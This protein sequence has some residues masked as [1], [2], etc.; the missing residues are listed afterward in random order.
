M[1]SSPESPDD[2]SVVVKEALARN[3]R[4]LREFIEALHICPYARTCREDGRLH[5]QVVLDRVPDAPHVAG[6]IRDLDERT[7]IEVGLLLFPRLRI[8]PRPFERFIG[9][10]CV[11]VIQPDLSRC[12]GLT[13]ARRVAQMAHDAGIDL[14]PHSWLTHLLTGYSL[15]LIAT[16]PRARF[17]EFNV[18]Q[19]AL[20][21]G[22]T[23]QPFRLE[24]GPSTSAHTWSR[25]TRGRK[26]PSSCSMI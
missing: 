3:D 6:L 18:S 21:R 26:R 16:L 14:V 11:D 19:S 25:P 2:A 12:G 23:T 13:V 1:S 7:D 24:A 8:E 20:T 4:Y 15:Q 22:I 10:G 9:D 17:V 5:R